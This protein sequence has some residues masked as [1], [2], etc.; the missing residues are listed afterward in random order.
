MAL[1]P[2]RIRE[3]SFKPARRATTRARSTPSSQEVA[4][5]LE[6]AQNEATAM[7]ARARAAVARLQELS[8]GGARPTPPPTGTPDPSRR[9]PTSRSPRRSR[10]RCCWPSARPTRPWPTPRPRPTGCSP[11]RSEDA[12]GR[13]DG[14]R[15]EAAELVEEAKVEARRAGEAERV[16]VES[17]VQALMARRDFLES[18]VEHLEQFVDRPAGADRRGRRRSCTALC[19]AGPG[20]AG[21]HAPPVAVGGLRAERTRA[22]DGHPGDR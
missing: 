14:A 12:A 7:E 13:L 4:G 2:Q 18:D 22:D 19:R 10:A 15:A 17:E 6:T 1:S 9:R 11:P 21:R 3:T 8:Q 20:R 5:A 16:R